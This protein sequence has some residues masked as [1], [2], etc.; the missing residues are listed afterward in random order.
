MTYYYTSYGWLS[1]EPIA[2]R[3][4]SV[5]PPAHGDK[6]VGQPFPNWTGFE[7]VLVEYSEPVIPVPVPLPRE[8][9]SKREFLKKFTPAEYAAIKA[10]ANANA[11]LDYYWQQFLLA[12]FIGMDDPDT[13]NGVNLLVLVGLLT[14][15]RAAEILA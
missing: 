12:E 11:E 4:T 1:H 6:E 5:E 7:W 2:G 13:I 15:E 8:P 9:I 14:V 10:A 3:E